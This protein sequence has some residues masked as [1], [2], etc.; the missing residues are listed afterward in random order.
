M[1]IDASFPPNFDPLCWPDDKQPSNVTYN[2]SKLATNP[3]LQQNT[4]L[5]SPS[6]DSRSSIP[7]MFGLKSNT[8]GKTPSQIPPLSPG[9]ATSPTAPSPTHI[10]SS[11]PVGATGSGYKQLRPTSPFFRAR[12]SREKAR[13]REK[14]PD[15]NALAKDLSVDSDGESVGSS[16]KFRPQASAYEDGDESGTEAEMEFQD[17]DTDRDDE[18]QSEIGQGS[19]MFDEETEK[20][21]EANAVFIEGDAAGLGGQLADAATSMIIGDER[22]VLDTFGEEVEQDP[23]GEGPNVVVPLPSIFPSA[24][25]EQLS[26]KKSIR[27]GLDLSTSRPIFARDRCTVTLTQG[28]PDAVLEGSGKRMRR[29][30]VLSDLSEESQYAVEWAIGTVARNGDEMFLIS[31]KEDESKGAF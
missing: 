4:A 8:A 15:I 31:V 9:S 12:R 23:L 19:D 25:A 5:T 16:R 21:T 28:D 11:K 3:R 26:H 1:Q 2:P 6:S 30:V 18:S 22:D 17:E 13:A 7:L 27:S 29:Y 20:N 24:P 10:Q 14:S